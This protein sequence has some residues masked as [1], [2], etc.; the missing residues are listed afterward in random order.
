MRPTASFLAF[1]IALGVA[2]CSDDAASA[3]QV[4]TNGGLSIQVPEDW[5]VAHPTAA[6]PCADLVGPAVVVGTFDAMANC[7]VDTDTGVEVLFGSGGP[8]EPPVPLGTPEE[9]VVNGVRSQVD[10]IGEPGDEGVYLALF[11]D[12]EGWLQV[13]AWPGGPASA[14][15]AGDR[16]LSTLRVAP[17]A[18]H[19]PAR[20]IEAFVGHWYVHGVQLEITELE[21]VYT[22]SHCGTTSCIEVD[23][24]SVQLSA[25]G[26][27][28]TAIVR[29]V[30]LVDP[31]TG[32][33]VAGLSGADPPDVHVGATSSF[34]FVAPH[35]LKEIPLDEVPHEERFG[36][37]Y[38]CGEQLAQVYS[39][40]CGA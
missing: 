9:R 4:L 12:W 11:P 7:Y 24:A 35:L 2:A 34:E 14:K 23:T 15:A 40:H 10:V 6:A 16:L 13:R 38:W 30:E 20:P 3:P 28:L 29:K 21:A 8:P 37:P 36:N 5:T 25:D 19:P 26:R 33:S 18:S 1:A 17:G 39:H 27:R 22:H 32:R 31:D